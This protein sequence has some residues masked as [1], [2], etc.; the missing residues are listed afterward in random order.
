MFSEA[1]QRALSLAVNDPGTAINIM[2]TMMS[3]LVKK[4]PSRE[5]NSLPD[6]NR[7]SIVEC[8]CSEWIYESFTPIS[9]DG[10]GILEMN[11]VMPKV[12]AS[13]WRNAVEEDVAE[14]ACNMAKQDLHHCE[15]EMSF[16]PD[17]EAVQKK[18]HSLLTNH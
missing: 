9:R 18:H 8:H 15:V 10:A 7:L 11:I 16:P 1:A 14:A 2:A 13:I 3:L 17:I 12:L 5:E 6:Y 4:S